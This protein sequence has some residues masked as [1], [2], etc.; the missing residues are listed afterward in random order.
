MKTTP[1]DVFAHVLAPNF[2]QQMLA[3]DATI[4]Q[5]A[6]YVQAQALINMTYQQTHTTTR[7]PT[8]WGNC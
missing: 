5:K 1:I 2:Y 3:I 6:P 8:D 4:P 7:Y